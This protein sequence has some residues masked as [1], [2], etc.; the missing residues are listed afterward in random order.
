MNILK[1]LKQNKEHCINFL[2]CKSCINYKSNS[3]S[4]LWFVCYSEDKFI[5]EFK[6][7]KFRKV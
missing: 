6:A 5:R 3:G 1:Y 7:L 4:K 2:D